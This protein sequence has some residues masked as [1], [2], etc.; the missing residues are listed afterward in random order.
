MTKNHTEERTSHQ[1]EN[2]NK[3]IEIINW[4]QIEIKT[5]KELKLKNITAKMKKIY[6]KYS[7]I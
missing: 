7:T 2:T 5:S 6:W 4:N 1:I 3:E